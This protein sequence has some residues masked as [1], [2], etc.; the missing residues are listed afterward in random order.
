MPILPPSAQTQAQAQAQAQEGEEEGASL[1]RSSETLENLERLRAHP[2]DALKDT[3]LDHHNPGLGLS[4]STPLPHQ[5]RPMRTEE[6]ADAVRAARV[7]QG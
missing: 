7:A 5:L 6:E 4:L 3:Q 1:P 2:P